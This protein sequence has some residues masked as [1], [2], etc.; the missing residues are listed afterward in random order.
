MATHTSQAPFLDVRSFIAEEAGPSPDVLEA[1]VSSVS[2]FLSLY[3][4]DEGGGVINPEAEEFTA[5]LN[6]LYDQEF[7][8]AM[9][10]LVSEAAALH[11]SRFGYEQENGWA[12]GSEAQRLLAQHFAPLVRESEAMIGD[13]ATELEYRSPSGV[14]EDEIQA[15]VD[16]YRP[17]E[18]FG[19]SFENFFGKLKKTF[20][21]V[22]KK[23][24]NL[25]KKG[26]S[27]AAKAGL[28]LFLKK[29]KLVVGPMVKT[30]LQ[31]AINKLPS[32][33]QP[34]ARKLAERL[35]LLKKPAAAP[36]PEPG[37]AA[38]SNIA[39]TSDS[40]AASDNAAASDD[41]ATSDNAATSN[42]GDI[43]QEF[44]QQ[45]ASL[46]F[47]P[48]VVEQELEVARILTEAQAPV[49]DSLSELDRARAQFVDEI[50]SLREGEDPTPHVERFIPAILPVLRVGL[51]IA[52]RPW[53]VRSLAKLVA[54][55]LKRFVGPE[56]AP[57]LSQAI[58]DAGLRLLSLEAAPEDEARAAGS[59]VAATVEET[60]RRVG[61]L[62]DYILDDQELLE[63]FALEAVEQAV[64]A[65]LPPVLTEATYR[66]RPDLLE[67]KSIR[68]TWLPMPLRGRRKP[69]KKWSRVRRIRL[70]P[71]MAS[72]V[73][74]FG[75]EP[76]AE[77]LEEQLGVPPGEDVEAQIHLY[78]ITPGA[79][80]SE[81]AQLEQNT[82]GLGSR[83]A[84]AQ[85]HP[86]TPEAA[87]ILLDEPKLGRAVGPRY[88]SNPYTTDVGQRF[89]Y[90]EVPGKRPLMTPGPD[91]RTRPRRRTRVSLTLDFRGNQILV[92]LYL[93]EIRAQELAVKLRQRAHL[94]AVVAFLGR[95]LERGM[96]SA[97]T[98]GFGRVKII[99]EA[100]TPCGW[101]DALQR[102]PSLVPRVLAGR[103]REWVVTGLADHLKQHAQQIIDATEEPADGI[104][105]V[106]TIAN[107]PG[108]PQLRQALRGKVL[109]LGSLRMSDGKPAVSIRITPGY[110]NE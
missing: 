33:L 88:L 40:T 108:F 48:G 14:T 79:L 68:G 42:L 57:A 53:L 77:F 11:E 71:H 66:Q 85:L 31:K 1:A 8:E 55:V 90:L 19:S 102:L 64:A 7:D 24:V 100:V 41:T 104:T 36:A 35:A 52:G 73:V 82:P 23:A 30:V 51:G 50:S 17:A 103:L 89:Y 28:G 84:Y 13:L 75:G 107:P 65:N 76:L 4:A 10:E 47:A 37:N 29:L 98:S 99:H 6:E 87:G 96:R 67:A 25:A 34:V 54:R 78:E 27:V 46:L 58:V 70:T 43:Q 26:V 63:G 56:Y 3:E 38:T 80:L 60:V 61:A 32:Q 105:L 18:E 97:L 45:V 94:G 86:L 20:A 101:L 44:Q 83:D 59:A 81:V 62:P 92:Y 12:N 91:G 21:K 93:S 74:S 110:A 39:A 69:Y 95:H 106:V 2:H 16:Q 22:A 15:F 109:S 5:F 9:F 72:A 49:N